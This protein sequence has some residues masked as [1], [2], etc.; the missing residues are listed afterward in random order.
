MHYSSTAAFEEELELVREKLKAKGREVPK[1]ETEF[2]ERGIKND[3]ELPYS[4]FP[5]STG[6]KWRVA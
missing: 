3:F 2:E 6:K 1:K 5:N 4:S